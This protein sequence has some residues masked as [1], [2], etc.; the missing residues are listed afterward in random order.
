MIPIIN[1]WGL[2]AV[3]VVGYLLGAY[4]QSRSIAHLDRR[5]DDLRDSLV[6]ASTICAIP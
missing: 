6:N 4:C 5:I 3:I 2:V 1:Q